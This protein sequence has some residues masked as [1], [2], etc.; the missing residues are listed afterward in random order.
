MDPDRAGFSLAQ[1]QARAPQLDLEW[2]SEGRSANDPHSGA[3]DEAEIGETLL[4]PVPRFNPTELAR[5]SGAQ[6]RERATNTRSS[7]GIRLV[8]P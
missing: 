3:A 2:I 7:R 5:L 6:A 1:T 8:R 4:R